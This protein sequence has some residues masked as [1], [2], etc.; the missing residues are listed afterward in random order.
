MKELTLDYT[1]NSYGGKEIYTEFLWGNPL[2]SGHFEDRG[3]GGII[4]MWI[5]GILIVR[6]YVQWRSYYR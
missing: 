3:D 2:G 1:C 4:L 6:M 5:F